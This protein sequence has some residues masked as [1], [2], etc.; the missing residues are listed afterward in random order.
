VEARALKNQ[1]C[2]NNNKIY[3]WVHIK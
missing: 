2:N 1:Y 3:V